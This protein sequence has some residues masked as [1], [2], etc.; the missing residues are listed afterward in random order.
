MEHHAASPTPGGLVA[1]AVACYTFVGVF[2]GLVP[3]EGLFLLGCWLLGGFVVQIL[4]ASKEIDHGVQLGGN[5]FLFFQGFFMLTGAISSMAKYLCLYVWETPFNTMA[6]GFGWLACTIALILWTPGYL[7][8]AN[9]PFATAVVFTDVA[10]IGVVLNDMYLLGAAA[11][12]VKPVV[13]ICLAIAGT[14][15]IYVASAIQLNSCFGRT[16]LPL[17]SPWIRDKATDHA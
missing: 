14:L 9:K 8:T 11:S 15:G 6:E 2:A 12:I 13:A 17:G 16:V 1:F 4:V 5:V 3:G 7:K 10:L